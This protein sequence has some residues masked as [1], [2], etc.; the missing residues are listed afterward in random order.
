MCEA[1]RAGQKVARTEAILL[2]A[3]VEREIDIR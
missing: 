2:A 3:A 1:W